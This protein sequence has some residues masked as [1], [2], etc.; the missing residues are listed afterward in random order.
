MLLLHAVIGINRLQPLHFR[1]QLLH[2]AHGFIGLVGK[3]IE[4]GFDKNGGDENG[5]TEIAR[6]GF[7]HF[8]KPE[9]GLGEE[10]EPTPVDHEIEMIQLQRVMIAIDDL[11]H[12]GTCK[13]PLH[14]SHTATRGD[15][16]GF[17]R[18]EIR[19]IAVTPTSPIIAKARA[20]LGIIGGDEGSSP[21][22]VR[23]PG[24]P[25]DRGRFNR[26]RTF[27]L[28]VSIINF[29]KLAFGHANQA[30]MQNIDVFSLGRAIALE[31]RIGEQ[32]HRGR[33]LVFNRA[34]DGEKIIVVNRD[35]LGEHQPFAIVIGQRHGACG[36]KLGIG[37]SC[38][39]CF[40][41]GKLGCCAGGCHIAIF[42]KKAFLGG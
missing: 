20:Y 19:L 7:E 23:E 31:A 27:F 10:I 17:L 9:Q 29:R 6:H 5:D 25:T 38:P 28:K 22:F 30:F 32:R 24:P 40:W 26:K 41:I 14:R 39:D 12:L 33:R 3:R 42:G 34:R 35:G 18:N 36:G 37:G 11:H 16:G 2:L 21:I 8:Q 13:Q 1:L 15:A 4:G